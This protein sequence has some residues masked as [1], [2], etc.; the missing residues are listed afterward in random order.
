VINWLIDWL[1]D[2]YKFEDVRIYSYKLYYIFV[3]AVVVVVSAQK[4][5]SP[6]IV[7]SFDKDVQYQYVFLL[8][9]FI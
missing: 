5:T 4:I 9:A 6:H 8:I 7:S 2:W 1:I 3:L